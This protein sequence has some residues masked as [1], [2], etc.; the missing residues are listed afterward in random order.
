MGVGG[1]SLGL[2]VC[3]SSILVGEVKCAPAFLL[4]AER[5]NNKHLCLQENKDID[6]N[7]IARATHYPFS[8]LIRT[9]PALKTKV[10]FSGPGTLVPRVSQGAFVSNDIRKHAM[11]RHRCMCSVSSFWDILHQTSG[12][13]F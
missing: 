8:C 4:A 3:F 12:P 10:T 1:F 2:F 6:L 5:R 13:R 11:R 9:Q 7:I